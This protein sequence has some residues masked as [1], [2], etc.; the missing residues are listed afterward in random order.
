MLVGGYT[1][2]RLPVRQIH[3][4]SIPGLVPMLLG[5]ALAFCALILFY[6]SRPVRDSEPDTIMATGSASRLALTVGLTLTYAIFLV[7]W[8][9]FFWATALFVF[10]FT[11]VFSWA[12][13]QDPRAQILTVVKSVVFGGVA[14]IAIV[15]LFEKAFLVRLP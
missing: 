9:P 14:A 3:P 6:Q 11:L 12:E 4:L 13:A 7:G 1:M 10:A 15:L 8:L 5:G 2:D